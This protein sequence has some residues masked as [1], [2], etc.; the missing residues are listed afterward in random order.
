LISC[1]SLVMPLGSH[2]ISRKVVFFPY[3]VLKMT[4]LSFKKPCH[5]RSLNSLVSTWEFLSLSS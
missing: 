2:Q 1:N 4:K 5:V 3:N